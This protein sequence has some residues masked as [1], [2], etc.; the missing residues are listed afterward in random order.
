MIIFLSALLCGFLLDNAAVNTVNTVHTDTAQ[1]EE[2]KQYKN[3][4]TDPGQ[5]AGSLHTL[6]LH[7]Y[8]VWI[9]L[10]HVNVKNHVKVMMIEHMLLFNCF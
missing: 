3:T 8:W 10:D 6:P 1:L 5:S 2:V 7:Q 9:Y 4:H